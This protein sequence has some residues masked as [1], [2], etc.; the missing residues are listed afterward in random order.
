[1]PSKYRITQKHI[2]DFLGIH[3][4]KKVV[5]IAPNQ[6]L[7]LKIEADFFS[8]N[9]ELSDLAL[10]RKT[11]KILMGSS[12]FCFWGLLTSDNRPNQHVYI[13]SGYYLAE[14]LKR[15]GFNVYEV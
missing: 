4:T 1:M 3:D 15:F 2:E 13:K 14:N 10:I 8:K 11:K 6:E 5:I 9:D 12:T 7:K